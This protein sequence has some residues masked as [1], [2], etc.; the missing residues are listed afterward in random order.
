[1]NELIID[2]ITTILSVFTGGIIAIYTSNLVNRK[3][4]KKEHTLDILKK[5]K[6]LLSEWSYDILEGG[7]EFTESSSID[8]YKGY[9]LS[10]SL[11]AL[12]NIF[13]INPNILKGFQ[14]EFTKI[15]NKD[16]QLQLSASKNKESLLELSQKYGTNDP[17]LML[18]KAEVNQIIEERSS[19]SLEIFEDIWSLIAKIDKHI[20]EKI[21]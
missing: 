1:M 9:H 8:K 20:A 18:E 21:L 7:V 13:K 11:R 17:M 19:K 2:V 10:L 5:V 4:L 15:R 14:K 12:I 3:L 16:L 6:E